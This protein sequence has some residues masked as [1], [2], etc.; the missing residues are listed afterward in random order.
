MPNDNVFQ[1]A[2]GT[3]LATFTQT[4]TYSSIVQLSRPIIGLYS[5]NF[6]SAAGSIILRASASPTGT[7]WPI[8]TASPVPAGDGT[9]LKVLAFGS[10]TFYALNTVITPA[11]LL[12]FLVLQIG[13][14]GTT[15]VAAGGTIVL[16]TAP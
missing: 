7:G 13:T 9:V 12:P 1:P 11:P 8:Q 6:P 14:A 5:D 3:A 15:A 16:V 4:G 10:G 2:W